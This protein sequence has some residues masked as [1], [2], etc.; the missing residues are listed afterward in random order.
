MTQPERQKLFH[1]SVKVLKKA[2]AFSEAMTKEQ[3]TRGTAMT[4]F[5]LTEECHKM[6][7]K[8][9]D[10]LGGDFAPKIE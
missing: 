8:L 4:L 10:T 1:E 7:R 3:V 2:A 9:L 6:S 5:Q